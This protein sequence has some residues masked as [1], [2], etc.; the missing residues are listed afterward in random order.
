MLIIALLFCSLNLLAVIRIS[1]L[2]YLQPLTEFLHRQ[3]LARLPENSN[4]LPELKALVCAENFSGLHVSEIFVASGLI[5]LF[6]VSG[7]HLLILQK[8]YDWLNPGWPKKIFFLFLFLYAGACQFN[9]P[10]ARS[11]VA[12][13]IAAYL[14]SKH[15]Y[16]PRH[17]CLL[18]VGF[19]TL[20]IEPQ[21]IQSISLQLSWLAAYV[22][23]TNQEFF[24]DRPFL[25]K[26]SLFFFV[27]FPVLIFFNVPSPLVI[28]VNL[29]F[30]PAL[31]FVLFPLGL[32]VWAISPI[33]PVFDFTI[34]ICKLILVAIDLNW[35]YQAKPAPSGWIIFNWSFIFTLH[36]CAHFAWLQ[37]KRNSTELS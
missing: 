8:I 24:Q 35:Q 30:A 20:L 36:L 6:V 5:H 27:L 33:F 23:A 7:S 18:I 2:H 26:Q 29:F 13:C 22:V 21:W 37:K 11:F 9:S 1:P 15:L 17:F 3:C 16:W 19:L 10:V 25:F 34:E 14:A 4:S 31:E 32:L 28:L 12:I